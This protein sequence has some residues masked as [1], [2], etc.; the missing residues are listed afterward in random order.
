M[1]KETNKVFNIKKKYQIIA[2]RRNEALM[3]V[4]TNENLT[5]LK[6]ISF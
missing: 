2:L 6:G 4:V 3:D 5:T 1:Q